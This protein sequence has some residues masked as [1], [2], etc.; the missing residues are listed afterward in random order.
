MSAKSEYTKQC[1]R[2]LG[3]VLKSTPRK[4]RKERNYYE[5]D[6]DVMDTE[7][8]TTLPRTRSNI[9]KAKTTRAGATRST[10]NIY[11]LTTALQQKCETLAARCSRQSDDIDVIEARAHQLSLE[12]NNKTIECEDIAAN[13]KAES[14]SNFELVTGYIRMYIGL[15]NLFW[16]VFVSSFDKILEKIDSILYF[17]WFGIES[18]AVKF[19]FC[20]PV[21]WFP[22][23]AS[24]LAISIPKKY[25]TSRDQFHINLVCLWLSCIMLWYFQSPMIMVMPATAIN[26]Y[27]YFT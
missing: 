18:V 9:K 1:L 2:Q 12:L 6:I 13:M 21:F 15:Y 11:S 7:E 10:E 16:I 19:V 5:N 3:E 24:P 8:E 27:Y 26:L 22:F 4:S 20:S 23:L 17:S 14:Q 25:S